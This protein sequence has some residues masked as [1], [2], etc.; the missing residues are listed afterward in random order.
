MNEMNAATP[1]RAARLQSP[2]D[3]QHFTPPSR[4]ASV[5]LADDEHLVSLAMTHALAS[6]GYV[7]V[8]PA[9]DGEQAVQLARQAMP[10]IAILDIRMPKRGG[11]S[12]AKELFRDL[13][14][15]VVIVS[16]YSDTEQV[17]AAS[18]VG[19]FGYL[20]KPVTPDQ[21]RATIEIA[22]S[23]YLR[24]VNERKQT[25]DLRKR[26]EDRRVIEQAKWLLVSKRDMAEPVAMQV[27]RQSA[28]DTRKGMV[29][30]AAGIIAELG[31][32][33]E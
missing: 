1:D 24:Y 29:E 7:T 27:L 16:A 13:L 30:V 19:V 11:I 28:R 33:T 26:L 15:P 20:V 23:S 5:L 17:N 31:E 2:Q 8:G 14:I 25:E 4:P 22:W 12:A 3:W 21:L 18:E 10:D 6:S 9:V 32:K